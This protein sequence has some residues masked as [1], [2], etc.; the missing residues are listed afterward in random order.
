MPRAD[1]VIPKNKSEETVLK[2]HTLLMK[3]DLQGFADIW[4]PDAVQEI[5]FPPEIESF[6]PIWAGKEKLLAYYNKA[7]PGR[8]DHV[9]DIL[10][11]HSTTDPNCVIVEATAHS[12]VVQTGQSYDQRYIFVFKLRDGKIV[13]NREHVNPLLFMKTFGPQGGAT[14]EP[15]I[16]HEAIR[17]L[18]RGGHSADKVKPKNEREAMALGFFSLLMKRDLDAFADLWTDDAVQE[19]PFGF[20]GLTPALT[21]KKEILDDYR[22]MF[23]NRSDHIFTIYDVHQTLDPDCLIVEARGV[24][25]IGETGGIYDNRY[26]ALFRLRDGKLAL[27]RFYFNPIISQAAFKGVLIGA[28]ISK[29]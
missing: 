9:F 29:Q 10:D 16:S 18:D 8:R 13:L 17:R 3:K 21:G 4:A 2:F 28:G 11:V 27:N 5:P 7:M 19:H 20:E 1:E 12:V 25:K 26:I 6:D 23:R 24:S 14:V 15:K 22:R